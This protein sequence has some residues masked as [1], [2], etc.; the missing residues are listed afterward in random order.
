MKSNDLVWA[1]KGSGTIVACLS[2]IYLIAI[3]SDAISDRKM[4]TQTSHSGHSTIHA[5]MAQELATARFGDL[6][7]TG[8]RVYVVSGP[9][10]KTVNDALD[11][12]PPN[13][14]GVGVSVGSPILGLAAEH[15][16]VVRR[17]SPEYQLILGE[18]FY[19]LTEGH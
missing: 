13:E 18:Y 6:I 11:A 1:I 5:E 17:G 3:V 15:F 19:R 10:P 14:Y 8:K 16:R 7:V 4:Q 2:L 12:Y 9:E